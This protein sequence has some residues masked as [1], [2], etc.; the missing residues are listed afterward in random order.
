MSD[1]INWYERVC[2]KSQELQTRIQPQVAAPVASGPSELHGKE[3]TTFTRV[4]ERSSI[5]VR[6]IINDLDTTKAELTILQAVLN[7]KEKQIEV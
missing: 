6:Q 4:E 2:L 1:L 3:Y 5:D 7:G